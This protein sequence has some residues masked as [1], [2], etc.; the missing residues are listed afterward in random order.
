MVTRKRNNS[1]VRKMS[2]RRGALERGNNS[3]KFWKG[4]LDKFPRNPKT[5]LL[6]KK[7]HW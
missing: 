4:K 7:L 6:K 3:L 2:R 1:N 5:K